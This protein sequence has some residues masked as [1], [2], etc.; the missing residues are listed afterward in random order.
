MLY[1]SNQDSDQKSG[2][3]LFWLLEIDKKIERLSTVTSS[4]KVYFNFKLFYEWTFNLKDQIL[5]Q[6]EIRNDIILREKNCITFSRTG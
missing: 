2:R 5:K 1:A 3:H 4:L 6:F